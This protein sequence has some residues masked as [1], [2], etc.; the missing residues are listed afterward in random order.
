MNE[1]TVKQMSALVP[2]ILDFNLQ[3][4]TPIA[5]WMFG[6][7]IL[8]IFLLRKYTLATWTE[9][10]PNPYSGE[11]LSMPRGVFRGILT[12]TL[13]FIIVFLEI[14]TIFHTGF[15]QEI[16]GFM[17]AFQMMIAFYFGSK[18][19]HHVTS[20]DRKKVIETSRHD[21]I[22]KEELSTKMS[23]AVSPVSS[24]SETQTMP[25]QDPNNGMN[26]E[27]QNETM[28]E[29]PPEDMMPPSDMM[30]PEEDNFEDKNNDDAPVG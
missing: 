24:F 3:I 19:M 9:D 12:M 8:F 30:S 18:V 27:T 1:E 7:L 21:T 6:V 28:D 29:Y 5:I 2:G 16:D 14:L 10:N 26:N 22:S 4:Y 25:I 23:P 11:T 13:L 15:E 17:T 20:A